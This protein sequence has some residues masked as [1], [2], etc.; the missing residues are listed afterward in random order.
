MIELLELEFIKENRSIAVMWFNSAEEMT[1]FIKYYNGA[2]SF[3]I[4]LRQT[5]RD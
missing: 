1:E 3:K 2:A 4:R 5:G